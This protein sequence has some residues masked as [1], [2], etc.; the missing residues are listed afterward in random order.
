MSSETAPSIETHASWVVAWS[1][2]IIM[3]IAYGAPLMVVVGLAPIAEGMGGQRGIPAL[4]SSLAYLGSGAGGV[5]MGLLAARL[6]ARATAM[7][8]GATI[9]AGLA[10]AAA[11]SA[12]QLLLAHAVFIGM[13]GTGALFAPMMTHASLFFDR[14]R[15]TALALVSSGQYIAGALWPS[16]FER[17]IAAW[18]WQRSMVVFGL[19]A[20]A[21]IVPLA[22]WALRRSPPAALAGSLAA[23]PPVGRKVLGLSP[24]LAQG[25]IAAASFLCCIP[26]AMPAA[27]LVAF[28]GD[29]GIAA[30]RG[31]LMLSLLLAAAFV[32]RQFWGWVAD[33]IGG[34]HAVLI[35]GVCQTAAMTGFLATQ[36][37]A[38]LFLVSILYG[39]G[40]GGI[41][42]AYVLAIRELFPASQAHWRVPVLLLVSLSGMATGA[43]LGGALYDAWG[44]YRGAF[45]VGIGAN[46]IQ[47]ALVLWL[48][49]RLAGGRR[50][51]AAAAA[52]GPR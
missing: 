19:C 25:L 40:F 6:G 43:W 17:M 49:T 51:V 9:A 26:M 13:F 46:L 12:W 29:L 11:G 21:A 42:P 22:A 47:V 24:N 31:A 3:G 2:T 50:Q 45:A 34:L 41:V 35:G 37:E 44:S 48:A 39:L 14:R 5:L 33:R 7:M 4:A 15:G 30:S 28:C 27:H 36:D 32:S 1:I 38:G 52:G 18:G 16:L 10:L 23:G 8:G 20:A